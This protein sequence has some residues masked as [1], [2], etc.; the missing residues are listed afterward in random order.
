[1]AEKH[2]LD[3]KALAEHMGV[4]EGYLRKYLV[5]SRTKRAH[6]T[7][8]PTDIPEP[9]IIIGRS[10]AWD[11]DTIDEWLAGRPGKGV[12]G[13]RPPKQDA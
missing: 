5:A 8:T 3:Y 11:Q 7:D 4:T 13:G 10:P 1:M 2:F 9:D 6:G 12:G